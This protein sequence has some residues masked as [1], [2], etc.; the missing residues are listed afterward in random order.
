M[1]RM[2]EV[3]GANGRLAN[4]RGQHKTCAS[5]ISRVR[6]RVAVLTIVSF[7]ASPIAPLVEAQAPAAKP[8]AAKPS[9]AAPGPAT[10]D[11]G[12]PRAYTTA[13]GAALVVYQPQVASWADQKHAV[14]YAAVSYTPKGATSPG[15]RHHQGG[16]R[17]ERGARR[18]ARELLGVQ[19][20]RVQLPH[21]PARS[22]QRP[23]SRKSPRRCRSTSA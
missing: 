22:A 13:S 19:D 10:A 12:W 14:L 9:A 4:L 16:I 3:I 2:A 17:H 8:A 21:A 23:S 5:F 7:L 6:A 15:A 20:H 18:A 11:E 1:R